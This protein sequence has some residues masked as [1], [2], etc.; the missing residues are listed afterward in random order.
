[1]W[2]GREWQKNGTS[3]KHYS[4]PDSLSN[5]ENKKRRKKAK[6]E[7]L[8]CVCFSTFHFTSIR[9]KEA[10]VTCQNATKE[11]GIFYDNQNKLLRNCKTWL[12]QQLLLPSF[13][14]SYLFFGLTQVH[15]AWRT[16]VF[17][18]YSWFKVQA[19]R[20][21]YLSFFRHMMNSYFLRKKS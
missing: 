7:K 11:I 21:I 10:S 13:F 1:L 8:M 3:T 15:V 2:V 20:Y 18:F 12:L 19:Y 16:F 6:R 5:H 4:L 9:S 14:F 17:M